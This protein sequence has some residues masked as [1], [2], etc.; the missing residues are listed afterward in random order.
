MKRRI[1]LPLA[2][3]RGGAWY[4]SDVVG[5]IA[6]VQLWLPRMAWHNGLGLRLVRS[7]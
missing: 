7:Q 4:C 2:V 3:L 1:N 5:L 6:S